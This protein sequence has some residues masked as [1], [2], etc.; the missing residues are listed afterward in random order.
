MWNTNRTLVRCCVMTGILVLVISTLIPGGLAA[1]PLEQEMAALG[2]MRFEGEIDAP[3][4]TAVTPGGE[5]L[6][7]S[8]YRGRLV[9]L[10]FWATW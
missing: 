2:L 1:T 10:N 4:G 8:D 7:L 5:Q 6:R 9:L 3:D